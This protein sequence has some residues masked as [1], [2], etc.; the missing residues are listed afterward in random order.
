MTN[1]ITCP[2]CNSKKVFMKLENETLPIPFSGPVSYEAEIYYCNECGASG[3]FRGV[4]GKITRAA[5]NKAGK[6]SA[7]P[8]IN[9][10][11][12]SDGLN[13]AYM[14]RSLDLPPR[15]MMRWKR[16]AITEAALAL[17]RLLRTFP[18]LIEIAQN[19]YDKTYAQQRLLEE[20]DLA[21]EHS[22]ISWDN[23]SPPLC[24]S[25]DI[26]YHIAFSEQPDPGS[27]IQ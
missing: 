23:V 26:T 5:V 24:G 16:G 22:E 10:L 7:R 11:V 12:E 19:Q 13:M 4:N 17:L 15:T 9:Q 1:K 27:Y 8:I 21:L 3:D 6:E 25:T 14:E 20:A 18:W 2:S